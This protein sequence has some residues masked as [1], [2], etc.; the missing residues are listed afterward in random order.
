MDDAL[1]RAAIEPI[2]SGTVVGLGTGRAAARGIRALAARREAETLRLTC[3]ATSEASAALAASL[4]LRV[5]ALDAVDRVDYLF[6]G[7]DEIDPQGRMIK[8]G[9][10]AMT[11]ERLVA[12][13][14][15]A[16]GGRRVFIA[17]RSKLVDRLG[18]TR[19]LP[20]EVLAVAVELVRRELASVGLRDAVLRVDAA[21][22][23]VITDNGGR[24]LDVRLEEALT[25]EELAAR[26]DAMPGVVDHGL[27]LR[28]AEEIVIEDGL[29]GLERRRRVIGGG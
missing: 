1:A 22:Q 19:R 11:R 25:L 14:A 12:A 9:G 4:G 29:G 5:V 16:S 15:M 28:E 17:D 18:A 2:Q 21:G 7:A 3:V 8:G 20:V 10:G 26:L 23:P 27:F 13:A 6:D 24:L